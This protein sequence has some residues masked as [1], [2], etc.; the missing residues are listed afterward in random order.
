MCKYQQHSTLASATTE[1]TIGNNLF[2][3][4]WVVYAQTQLCISWP[5]LL[6]CTP[7]LLHTEKPA[8][9]RAR[10]F[11]S[12]RETEQC[13][14]EL[15]TFQKP[16]RRKSIKRLVLLGHHLGL[17][18]RRFSVRSVNCVLPASTVAEASFRCTLESSRLQTKLARRQKSMQ[19]RPHAQKEIHAHSQF[20]SGIVEHQ[21]E[22]WLSQGIV[23]TECPILRTTPTQL[24]HSCNL[25]ART[26]RKK[27]YKNK[28]N[29]VLNTRHQCACLY[30]CVRVLT[31]V[32]HGYMQ[33]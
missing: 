5:C 12:L 22:R 8:P 13:S 15:S 3:S 14:F 33:S 6:A 17:K 23:T 9:G 1:Q 29:V 25:W 11:S 30:V 10:K 32:R 16:A 4:H 19:A 7:S 24:I 27:G 31:D 28:T 18:S 2:H 21:T 20:L 26:H